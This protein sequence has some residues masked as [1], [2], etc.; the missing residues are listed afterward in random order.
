M[1]QKL[2]P[3][4]ASSVLTPEG[5]VL[6]GKRGLF[7]SSIWGKLFPSSDHSLVTAYL[8]RESSWLQ[9]PVKPEKL[10]SGQWKTLRCLCC[11]NNWLPQRVVRM[12]IPKEHM[13]RLREGLIE[14]THMVM[15]NQLRKTY[16]LA[17]K[18]IHNTVNM[19]HYYCNCN[20][21]SLY[22]VSPLKYLNPGS[23]K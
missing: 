1:R 10:Q 2:L 9:E 5:L 19:K 3:H 13:E 22:L 14:R 20:L 17:Q 18:E 21:V 8:H 4:T 12:K 15:L 11:S 16:V 23:P 6:G 7:P